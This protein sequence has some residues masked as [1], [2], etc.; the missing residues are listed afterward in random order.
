MTA[1]LIFAGI[2]ALSWKHLS[3]NVRRITAA[4]LVIGFLGSVLP[5]LVA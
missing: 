4:C 5:I 1:Y 3:G 2:C